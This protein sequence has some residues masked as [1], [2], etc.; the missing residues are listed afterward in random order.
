VAGKVSV[1]LV[2]L[3]VF[4]VIVAGTMTLRLLMSGD[5]ADDNLTEGPAP[6]PTATVSASPSALIP[7]PTPSAT[8]PSPS[9]SPS[10]VMV[11]SPRPSASAAPPPPPAAWNLVWSDEFDGSAVDGSKWNVAS[12]EAWSLDASCHTSRPENVSV[13]GGFLTLRAHEEAYDC[14]ETPRPYTGA[15]LTSSQLWLRGAVEVRVRTG[16][17][18]P[19]QWPGAWLSSGS[20]GIDLAEFYGDTGGASQA[21]YAGGG[22]YN[23][24]PMSTTDFHVY[25]AEWEAT[26]VRWYIDG[27][28]VWTRDAT[29]LTAACAVHLDF[30]VG[31]SAAGQPAGSPFPNEFVV[32]YVRVYQR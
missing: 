19:G 17:L 9:A 22:V 5:T 16:T 26:Q 1:F 13:S 15:H 32:D 29:G 2:G 7:G 11:A 12:A 23:T 6:T 18:G 25:R 31:G 28:L 20:S 14:A 3:G 10:P 21:I 4:L 8:T 24:V 30:N 27:T